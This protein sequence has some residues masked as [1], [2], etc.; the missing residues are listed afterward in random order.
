MKLCELC[1]TEISVYSRFCKPHA[2]D[3]RKDRDRARKRQQYQDGAAYAKVRDAQIRQR[4][5]KR[6]FVCDYL[7]VNPCVDCGESDILVLEFDHL[8]DKEGDVNRMMNG[9][10]SLKRMQAEIAKCEVR[11]CNC[12]RRQTVLRLGGS[13]RTRYKPS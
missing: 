4:E 13:Y 2:E 11:C 6:A 7:S 12:H 5:T 9:G 1:P 8:G 3:R 10:C